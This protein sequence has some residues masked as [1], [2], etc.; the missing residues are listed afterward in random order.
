MTLLR[1]LIFWLT[2]G[3]ALGL[4]LQSV[5]A[6]E[7]HGHRGARGLAPENTLPAVATALAIGVHAIELD[8]A[9]TKDDVVVVTHD[10]VLKGEK[11]RDPSGGWIGDTERLVVRDLT[12]EELRSFDVGRPRPGGR[13]ARSFPEQKAFDG[14]R[15]PRLADVFAMVKSAGNDTVR[16]N[17]EIKTSPYYPDESPEPDRFAELL[18]EL[19]RQ[20]GLETRTVVQSLDWRALQALQK[21]APGIPTSYLTAERS[22]LDNIERGKPGSSAWT[23]G[24]DADAYPSVPA[25]VKAAGGHIWSPYYPGVTAA[26]IRDAHALGLQVL[27]WTVNEPIDMERMI[28]MGVDGIITDRPDLARRE[29]ARYKKPLP[30]TTKLPN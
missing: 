24:L 9:V 21:I 7:L 14:A 20:A 15:I 8:L 22:W 11:V 23:A 13:T 3:A 26:E 2:A 4:A 1:P 19:V 18:V 28:L 12:F 30:P 16:F 27:V 25:M 6:V 29:L 10:P 5:A 17:L